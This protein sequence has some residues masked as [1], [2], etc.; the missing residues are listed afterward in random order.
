M[1][2]FWLEDTHWFDDSTLRFFLH[3]YSLSHDSSLILIRT[4]RP[5][6]E[7]VSAFGRGSRRYDL[8][9]LSR[10]ESRNLLA[11]WAESEALTDSIRD[12]MVASSEGNPFHLKQLFAWWKDNPDGASSSISRGACPATFIDLIHQRTSTL[13][14]HQLDCLRQAALIGQVFWEEALVSRGKNVLKDLAS[15]GFIQKLA[16]SILEGTSAWQ[17]THARLPE[18]IREAIPA[19]KSKDWSVQLAKRLQDI[20]P[21]SGEREDFGALIAS[22]YEAGEAFSKAA[23]FW[24]LAGYRAKRLW[25][26]SSAKQFF[27]RALS[28]AK[29]PC[30][31]D[32]CKARFELLAQRSFTGRHDLEE[33]ERLAGEL[34][35]DA[36]ESLRFRVA[37]LRLV[38]LIRLQAF[39]EVMQELP[40]L[41]ASF[42]LREN[43]RE[44]DEIRY[45][46]GIAC[47][48]LRDL[49]TAIAKFKQVIASNA[50][51]RSADDLST[52]SRQLLG[53]CAMRQ[54]DT[55]TAGIEWNAALISARRLRD[56]ATESTLLN[57]LAHLHGQT[58]RWVDAW[59]RLHETVALAQKMGDQHML[60]RGF[61]NLGHALW[62][63]GMMGE[64]IQ[65][66]ERSRTIAEEMRDARGLSLCHSNLGLV[67]FTSG[68]L[69]KAE[70]NLKKS[71]QA[72]REREDDSHTA[73]CLRF[74]GEVT[75]SRR[76]FANA[77]SLYTEAGVLYQ[78]LGTLPQAIECKTA[79][80]DLTH[81][82]LSL[83][84]DMAVK[85]L[86]A[87][88]FPELFLSRLQ[89]PAIC[90]GERPVAIRENLRLAFVEIL[91]RESAS[92]DAEAKSAFWNAALL[93]DHLIDAG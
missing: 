61:G 52:R 69:E 22:L 32:A 81:E 7:A 31:L 44:I 24:L 13:S 50:V 87:M 45:L 49:P 48:H 71:L 90:C 73:F 28:C 12:K 91:H 82:R 93:R 15:R 68:R 26:L 38:S 10:L 39:K 5:E 29:N 92:L 37:H 47:F 40:L 51:H 11:D 64:A 14:P 30:G 41:Y 72:A 76:Q 54:Q 79:L 1:L 33:V 17:F 75:H 19:P 4:C 88:E 78:R 83:D 67:Y 16:V 20:V 62:R 6:A 63:L 80:A 25:E 35:S 55:A 85:D 21:S 77:R 70:N 59:K 18:V 23:S 86:L 89:D 34:P 58:G 53:M 46:E 66:Q 74:L 56:R 27:E 65:A 43:T 8:S 3:L 2:V 57:N 9:P 84:A 42:A 36:P 60:M